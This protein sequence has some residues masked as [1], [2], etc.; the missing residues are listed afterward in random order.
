MPTTPFKP[1]EAP[2]GAVF[3]EVG[4]FELPRQY[5]PIHEEAERGRSLGGIVDRSDWSKLWITGK[6]ALEFL[7]NYTTNNLMALQPG[8]GLSTAI[9]TWKG[10]M[11]DHVFLQREGDG[12]RMLAHPGRAGAIRRALET[13]MLNVDVK[14]EDHTHAQGML[15]VFGSLARALLLQATGLRELGAMHEPLRARIA[16]ALVVVVKTWPLGAEGYHLLVQAEAAPAVFTAIAELAD[17]K[18]VLP[19][20]FEAAE[21]LRVEAGIPV[22]GHEIGED[23]NPWEARLSGSVSMAKGCY[24]GQEVVARLANYDK[25]QRYV[26]GLRLSGSQSPAQGAEIQKD[27]QKVGVVTSAVPGTALGFVKTAFAA[28]GTT[29][30]VEVA[31]AQV[32]AV[33]EA[34]P[35]WRE[36]A[37]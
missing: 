23:V 17:A 34:M 29:V 10:T 9:T 19:L 27:G 21:I 35:F 26:M 3:A 15:L 1:A 30:V 22:F 6:D 16:G 31:G 13:F 18:G 12:L 11:V 14:I 28:P 5:L 20:G 33:L 32:P 36:S 8:Q 7:N 2:L 24:L 4:G 25:V 37:P